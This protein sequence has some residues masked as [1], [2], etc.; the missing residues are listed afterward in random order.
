VA[1]SAFRQTTRFYL[2]YLSLSLSLSLPLAL[3]FGFFVAEYV[4]GY[5]VTILRALQVRAREGGERGAGEKEGEIYRFGNLS[6][7]FTARYLRARPYEQ[8][9]GRKLYRVYCEMNL[10]DASHSRSKSPAK[11]PP[12]LSIHLSVYLCLFPTFSTDWRKFGGP[13]NLETLPGWIPRPEKSAHSRRCP[14]T[15]PF[16]R[17]PPSRPPPSHP[18]VVCPLSWSSLCVVRTSPRENGVL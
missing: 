16:P 10:D 7:S 17:L 9:S 12:S 2:P 18:I 15:S 6:V 5:G 14:R 4:T 13:E 11:L 8:K 1:L 3:R